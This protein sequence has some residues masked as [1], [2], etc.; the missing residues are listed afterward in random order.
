MFKE[1]N[2]QIIGSVDDDETCVLFIYDG[3]NG[4]ISMCVIKDKS[5]RWTALGFNYK[6]EIDCMIKILKKC[7]KKLP[8]NIIPTT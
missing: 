3:E 5:G 7:K 6:E 8:S 4:D 1:R 2:E